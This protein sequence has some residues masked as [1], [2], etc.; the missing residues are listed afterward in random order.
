MYISI[1]IRSLNPKNVIIK[2]NF[3]G[4]SKTKS[5]CLSEM[6]QRS[7]PAANDSVSLSKSIGRAGI[8]NFSECLLFL[9]L[10][11]VRTTRQGAGLGACG[12]TIFYLLAVVHLGLSW[13]SWC[14]YTGGQSS[15]P[16]TRHAVV[17]TCSKQIQS[18]IRRAAVCGCLRQK[19]IYHTA[20]PS[21]TAATAAKLHP[22]QKAPKEGCMRKFVS[23][24]RLL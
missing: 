20:V 1:H 2:D 10:L 14:L 3:I 17:A 5:V 24:Q 21:K 8:C 16:R 7:T 6:W 23:C 19:V 12:V 9:R 18:Q 13:L 11:C 4:H 22:A 15:S